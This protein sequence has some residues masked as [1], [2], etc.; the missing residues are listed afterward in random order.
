MK[1]LTITSVPMINNHMLV[2]VNNLAERSID[3]IQNLVLSC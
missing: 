2:Y 3:Q 1:S